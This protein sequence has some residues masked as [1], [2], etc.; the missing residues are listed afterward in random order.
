MKLELNEINK[1]NTIIKEGLVDDKPSATIR[2]LARYYHQ[3]GMDIGQIIKIIDAFMLKNYS[4]KYNSVTWEDMIE[5][6][7]KNAIKNNK[8][9][10]QVNDVNITETEINYIKSLGNDKFQKLAFTYLVYAKIL[11]QMN[12]LNS[13]WIGG[14]YRNEIFKDAHVKELGKD[15]LKTIHNMSKCN[16]L[17]LSK[18]IANNSISVDNYIDEDSS[19]I[20]IIDDFREL[21]LQWMQYKGDESI[22]KCECCNKRF[23]LK[24]S[25]SNQKYCKECAK[26]IK[27]EQNKTYYRS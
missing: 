23:K 27:N 15:Q 7:V 8:C 3:Q 21:G 25:N 9:L 18:D 14:K 5:G 12:S 19:I 26:N 11:N 16:I 20:W 4:H 6:T 2:L 17:K 22:K 10:M 1:V 24:T 13:N